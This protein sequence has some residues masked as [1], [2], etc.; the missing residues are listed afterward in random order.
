MDKDDWQGM[1]ADKQLRDLLGQLRDQ[2]PHLKAKVHVFG[3]GVSLILTQPTGADVAKIIYEKN[4][5][6]LTLAGQAPKRV[7]FDQAE[8]LLE[9]TL[10]TLS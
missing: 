1:Q 2:Y 8:K 6:T 9:E 10:A 7:T 3:G 4:Q 5:Y